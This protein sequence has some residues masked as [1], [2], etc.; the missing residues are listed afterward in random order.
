MA[1]AA[2]ITTSNLVLPDEI[3]K[4]ISGEFGYTPAGVAEGWYYK[5]TDVTNTS[6]ALISQDAFLQ[7]GTTA[8][9]EDTGTNMEIVSPLDEVKFLFIKHTSERDDGTTDNTADSIYVSFDGGGAAHNGTTSLEIGPGE[10]FH[11]KPG[12]TVQNLHAISAQKA[13]A[14]TSVNKVQAIVCAIIKNV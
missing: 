9:G 3:A 10:T 2:V 8:A 12:C 11:C 14:G 5:L 4:T 13:K 6:T 7:M 1:D